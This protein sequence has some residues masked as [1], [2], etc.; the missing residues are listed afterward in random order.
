MGREGS[1][2]VFLMPKVY[3]FAPIFYILTQYAIMIPMIT[4]YVYSF[5]EEAY[6]EFLRLRR[7]PLQEGKLLEDAPD[8]VPQVRR[9]C[10]VATSLFYSS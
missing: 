1:S 2:I 7:V 5:Q 8:I 4:T 10:A 9:I 6:V 3:F